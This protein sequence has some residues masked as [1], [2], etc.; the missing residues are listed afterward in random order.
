MNKVKFLMSFALTLGIL[1]QFSCEKNVEEDMGMNDPNEMECEPGTSFSMDVKPIIDNNC[2]SC[3]N[4]SVQNPDLRTYQAIKNNS[5]RIK[6]LTASRVMPQ[7]GSLT[8]DQII[9]I[10]CWVDDGAPDN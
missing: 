2:I 5:A 10:G 6:E 3:H 4:G 1:I 8:D 9:L 7:T